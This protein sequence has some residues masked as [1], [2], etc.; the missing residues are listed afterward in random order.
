M[1]FFGSKLPRN[2]ILTMRNPSDPMLETVLAM[3]T[4]MPW[5]IDITA[6]SVVVARMIPSRVRKLRNLLERSESA[7]MDATS[8]NEA[9]W[10]TS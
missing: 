6:I 8:R 1:N 2:A 10:A 7:A 5:I 4:S 3:Y 9:V